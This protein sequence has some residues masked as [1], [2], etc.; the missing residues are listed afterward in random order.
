MCEEDDV[1]L[2]LTLRSYASSVWRRS[3]ISYVASGSEFFCLWEDD[4]VGG[5][6]EYYACRRSMHVV[7]EEDACSV[8]GGG[9]SGRRRMHVVYEE[10][11]CRRMHVV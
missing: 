1:Y 7:Q 8:R 2:R 4:M 9:M 11:A 5:T 3:L 10:D 6:E